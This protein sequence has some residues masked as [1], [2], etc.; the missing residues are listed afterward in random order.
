MLKW[1]N[2]YQNYGALKFLRYTGQMKLN[3]A[4]K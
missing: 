4:E 2:E 3:D 1:L